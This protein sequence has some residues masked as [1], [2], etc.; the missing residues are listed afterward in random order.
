V[1]NSNL[2][3]IVKVFAQSELITVDAKA[4]REYT[5][6]GMSNTDYIV[7]TSF[8]FIS[9]NGLDVTI[10]RSAESNKTIYLW[11]NN[12]SSKNVN[13]TN[14]YICIKKLT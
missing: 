6:G 2:T 10:G 12:S 11:N 1:L 9:D 14:V 7:L 4:K 5:F 8:P 3:D 13:V